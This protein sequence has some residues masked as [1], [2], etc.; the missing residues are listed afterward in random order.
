MKDNQTLEEGQK[1]A[2]DLMSK[3]GVEQNDLVTG[4]YMDLICATKES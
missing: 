3:L 1:I 4:A 2:E